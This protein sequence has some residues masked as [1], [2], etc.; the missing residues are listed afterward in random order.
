M[1]KSLVDIANQMHCANPAARFAFEFWD[2][3][4]VVYG[5]RPEVILQFKSRE[6]A[7]QLLRKGFFGLGEGYM[8]GDLEVEGNLQELL[9]LIQVSL[10]KKQPK[11]RLSGSRSFNLAMDLQKALTTQQ[12]LMLA[13]TRP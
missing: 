2:G 12:I 8:A 3:E 13:L 1:K 7:K 5:D 10:L 11:L 9:R 6:G 4:D